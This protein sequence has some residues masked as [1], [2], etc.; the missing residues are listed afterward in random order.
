MDEAAELAEVIT[1]SD[2]IVLATLRESIK[3]AYLETESLANGGAVTLTPEIAAIWDQAV[4]LAW[5]RARTARD[6]E[7][8]TRALEQARSEIHARAGDVGGSDEWVAGAR[9]V[10][11]QLSFRA[12]TETV[13]AR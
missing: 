9:F 6:A 2:D 7:A 5:S 8:A 12:K 13:E 11:D 10:L 4:E 3:S 1:L